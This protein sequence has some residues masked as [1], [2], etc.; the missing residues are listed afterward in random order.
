MTWFSTLKEEQ[1]I[2]EKH[3][4]KCVVIPLATIKLFLVNIICFRLTNC[5]G[6]VHDA[7]L[8]DTK[9]PFVDFC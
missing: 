8:Y 2:P 5:T 9:A 7:V 1:Q 4:R 6:N 3:F